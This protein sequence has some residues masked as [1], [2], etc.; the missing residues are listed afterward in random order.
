[1][2]H[3]HPADITQTIKEKRVSLLKTSQTPMQWL[4]FAS[5]LSLKNQLQGAVRR[6]N[7]KIQILLVGRGQA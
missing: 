3:T 7:Q 5:L 1:M 6:G 4:S 2:A